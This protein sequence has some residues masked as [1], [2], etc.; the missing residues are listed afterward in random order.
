M[1]DDEKLVMGTISLEALKKLEKLI[2]ESLPEIETD[3]ERAGL[4]QF[5]ELAYELAWKTLRKVLEQQG[6]T[7]KGGPKAIFREAARA[8]II[9]NPDLWFEFI[10]RRNETVHAYNEEVVER[11]V[12]E[13]PIFLAELRKLIINLES[14][15]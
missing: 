2:A 12:I 13:V 4:I 8:N 1:S 10:E 7:I 3:L 14:L 5:F 11:V 6:F 9:D 15:K